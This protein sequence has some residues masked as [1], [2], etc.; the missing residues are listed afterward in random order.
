[1]NE[2][3]TT[4]HLVSGGCFLRQLQRNE[5]FISLE[6]LDTM[7]STPD[8]L[9][10][11]QTLHLVNHALPCQSHDVAHFLRALPRALEVFPQGKA[12]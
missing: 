6:S 1:M 4:I 7:V 11:L 9:S 5:P 10:V 3:N 12:S 8:C 2:C